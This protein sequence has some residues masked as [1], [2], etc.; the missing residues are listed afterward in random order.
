MDEK[1]KKKLAAIAGVA[2]FLKTEAEAAA[3]FAAQAGQAEPAPASL[4]APPDINLWGT[5]G[6]Q[7]QMQMRSLMQMKA[8]HRIR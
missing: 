2:Q 6:R 7:A 3:Q 8:F 1:R 5:T 4:C